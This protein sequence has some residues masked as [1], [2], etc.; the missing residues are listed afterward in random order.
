MLSRIGFHKTRQGY[1]T[2]LL[3]LLVNF[4]SQRQYNVIGIEQASYPSIQAFAEKYGF[5]K[6]EGT[7]HFTAFTRQLAT[8]L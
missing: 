1:G 5:N 3:K 7:K 4:A 6:M 8:K 2:D